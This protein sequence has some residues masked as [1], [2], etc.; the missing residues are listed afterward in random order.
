MSNSGDKIVDAS[1]YL[2]YVNIISPHGIHTGNRDENH[3]VS[4]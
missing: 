4:A 2:A 1:Y 3:S